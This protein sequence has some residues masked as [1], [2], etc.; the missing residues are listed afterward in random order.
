MIFERTIHDQQTEPVTDYN[1]TL[2]L[3]KPWSLSP[4]RWSAL[5]RIAGRHHVSYLGRIHRN[6]HGRL[7]ETLVG[8]MRHYV[9]IFTLSISS[10]ALLNDT[11]KLDEQ[12]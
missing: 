4:E 8:G 9:C 10:E 2:R 7:T 11:P 3:Q 12:Q 6:T 5:Q 1:S